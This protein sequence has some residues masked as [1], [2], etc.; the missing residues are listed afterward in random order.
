MRP[1]SLHHIRGPRAAI[2]AGLAVA[3]GRAWV[4]PA[5]HMALW[6]DMLAARRRHGSLAAALARAA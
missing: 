5:H 1:A 3:T 4:R 2:L 6:H